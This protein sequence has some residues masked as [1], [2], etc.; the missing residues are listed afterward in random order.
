MIADEAGMNVLLITG[1]I[2]IYP[3]TVPIITGMTTLRGVWSIGEVVAASDGARSFITSANYNVS[4]TLI[5]MDI[6]HNSG[7]KQWGEG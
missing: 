7:T 5:V 2:G 3:V 6:T 4:Q 1:V